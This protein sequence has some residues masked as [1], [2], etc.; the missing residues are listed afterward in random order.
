M[1]LKFLSS[2]VSRPK[3]I[4]NGPESRVNDLP[5]LSYPP[6]PPLTVVIL[7]LQLL[8]LHSPPLFFTCG[9]S[10]YMDH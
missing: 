7:L 6:P 10:R 4:L 9:E 2:L 1:L 3:A 5:R 8:P